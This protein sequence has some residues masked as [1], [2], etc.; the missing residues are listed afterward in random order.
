MK[1][2]LRNVLAFF[3]AN[4]FILSG[5]VR[6]AKKRAL[7]G[8]HIL[9]IYFH[10]PSKEEFEFVIKWL[11]KNGFSFISMHDLQEIMERKRPFPKGAVLM[12]VDDGWASNVPNLVELAHQE[13][14]PIT[15]FVATEAI[16]EGNYWFNYAKMAYK[17]DLGFPSSEEMKK[18][19]NQDRLDILSQIKSQ[20]NLTR[21]AMTVEELKEISSSEWVT[22]G[23]HSHSHAILNQCNDEEL[24]H[25]VTHCKIMIEDWLQK[26]IDT[27]AYPNGDFGEREMKAL[28]SA[29]YRIGFVNKPKYLT[30]SALEEK[31]QIPRI[32]LL[33]GASKAEN[34]CRM[35]GVWRKVF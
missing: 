31:Y 19:P 14:V 5:M 28:K 15:I 12:T 8:D 17:A 26:D 27:F 24:I 30:Q 7:K 34:I 2:K 13:K 16:E 10:Y 6:K 11:K 21:E 25:E 4:A 9:S 23:G 1:F 3:V 29:G 33:E 20:L 18:L 32:G 35:M 22:I